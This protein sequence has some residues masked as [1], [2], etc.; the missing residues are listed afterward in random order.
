MTDAVLPFPLEGRD[1]NV[2]VGDQHPLRTVGA[3]NVRPSD[4]VTGRLSGSMRAGTAKWNGTALGGTQVQA[5]VGAMVDTGHLDHAEKQTALKAWSAAT[6]TGGDAA[7]VVFDQTGQAFIVDGGSTITIL[8]HTGTKG[9]NAST[10]T[11][12]V[13]VDNPRQRENT[14]FCCIAI[15]GY[16]RVYVGSSRGGVKSSARLVCLQLNVDLEDYEKLWELDLG[17]YI[18]R[19]RVHKAYLYA[20]INDTES[21]TA[22][23][24]KLQLLGAAMPSIEWRRAVMAPATGLDVLA[25]GDVVVSAGVNRTGRLVDPRYISGPR[26]SDQWAAWKPWSN[27][28]SYDDEQF[29]TIDPAQLE[30]KDGDP[31][32]TVLCADGSPRRLD[33]L[34]EAFVE[35][36][37]VGSLKS[38]GA[39]A[40]GTPIYT[41]RYPAVY[42][43]LVMFTSPGPSAG[44]TLSFESDTG[45]VETWT[46]VTATATQPY[47][48]VIGASLTATATNII[49]AINDSTAAT[50]AG[51]SRLVKARKKTTISTVEVVTFEALESTFEVFCTVGGSGVNARLTWSN[52]QG[53][54]IQRPV[55]YPTGAEVVGY[56]RSGK[57][58]PLRPPVYRKLGRAGFPALSFEEPFM[59][60]MSG[61][62]PNRGSAAEIARKTHLS[63]LPKWHA[64]Q[65]ST[66]ARVMAFWVIRPDSATAP[67]PVHT[68][69]LDKTSWLR[70][71]A[72]GAGRGEQAVPA[73]PYITAYPTYRPGA[74]ALS[75]NVGSTFHTFTGYYENPQAPQL[76]SSSGVV[77]VALVTDPEGNTEVFY[78]GWPGV[79]QR[80]PV[81]TGRAA[82]V[83]VS[84]AS[85]SLGDIFFRTTGNAYLNVVAGDLLYHT[86][87]ASGVATGFYYVL[88]ATPGVP[89][90]VQYDDGGGSPVNVIT[91]SIDEGVCFDVY[92]DATG[93]LQL[94]GVG[95]SI[96]GASPTH[97][98]VTAGTGLTNLP[99]LAEIGSIDD[100]D[101]VTLNDKLGINVVDGTIV[102]QAL[103]CVAPSRPLPGEA[104]G[105][106]VLGFDATWG[107]FRGDVLFYH[108]VSRITD[109]TPQDRQLWEGY[110]AWR[111]GISDA[112]PASHPHATKPPSS[113]G[114]TAG[115]SDAQK[116]TCDA[117]ALMK[118]RGNSGRVAWI[119]VTDDGGYGSGVSIGGLGVDC[120][121]D[122]AGGIYSI[123]MRTG[124]DDAQIR[125]VI[126]KGSTYSLA[127]GDGAW[128]DDLD[129]NDNITEGLNQYQS[130]RISVDKQGRLYVPTWAP[131]YQGI[132]PAWRRYERAGTL[133]YEHINTDKL[134]PYR[135]AISPLSNEVDIA[136]AGYP[137]RLVL[138]CQ[139]KR[140][141]TLTFSAQPAA[142]ATI[143]LTNPASG[144][145]VFTF[146]VGAPANEAE[147]Q[148]GADL[149]ASIQNLKTQLEAFNAS[150]SLGHC[151]VLVEATTATTITLLS[152][153]D[154]EEGELVVARSSSPAAN[155]TVGAHTISGDA[156]YAYD[157]VTSTLID[158]PREHFAVA[159]IGGGVRMATPTSIITPTGGLSL[160]SAA[161]Y[162]SCVPMFGHVFMVDGTS[163]LDLDLAKRTL[164]ELKPKGR[165]F[166]P[167]KC[168]ILESYL[169]A[170]F[171]AGDPNS[172][173]N[174]FMSKRGD[175]YD[176][177][178]YPFGGPFANQA[179]E[180]TISL[181]G[182]APVAINGAVNIVDDLLLILGDDQIWRL[183]G[184]PMSNGRFDMVSGRVGCAF[185]RAWE[186]DPAGRQVFFWNP[187]DGLYVTNGLQAEP[188]LPGRLTR[189]MRDIDLTKFRVRMAW[190]FLLDG[191][192]IF[193]CPLP[194]TTES[195]I[196]FWWDRKTNGLWEDSRS[197]S[198]ADVT[199]VTVINGD[200]P[201]DR[202][203]LMGTRAGFLAKWDPAGDDLGSPVNSWVLIGPIKAGN[204]RYETMFARLQV[205]LEQYAG[206]ATVNVYTSETASGPRRLR[207]SYTLTPGL[208]VPLSARTAGGY[209][210]IELQSQDR[211]VLER[212]SAVLSQ[213]SS[214]R[215]RVQ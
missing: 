164:S 95:L 157:V 104:F 167:Q 86:A 4:P 163:T 201:Q 119:A 62:N 42:C 49:N 206:S 11:P 193:V 196:S 207:H 178:Y 144:S 27:Y 82:L 133:T 26:L 105:R 198:T 109:W 151:H 103:V 185:G 153:V 76:V 181:A 143:T 99:I 102:A 111:F 169:G 2:S 100:D 155:C 187:D 137:T 8:Q 173:Q 50:E 79:A 147:V 97:V 94:N 184:D 46:F 63:L 36:G 140:T 121:H 92:R 72:N 10:I 58:A 78:N 191:L 75:Y 182:L 215:L 19:I 89:T 141:I 212:M 168:Q 98:L 6:Q 126:D 3:Q 39:E 150:A 59:S 14:E 132:P 172:R 56:C 23:A 130:L 85:N 55:A 165:G 101:R 192:D 73:D 93:E 51:A 65:A 136:G 70:L 161:S 148:I 87:G 204:P 205:V 142:N 183:T 176:Y 128:A 123:G 202:M 154:A 71:W 77:L 64:G 108:A 190:N 115:F 188:V 203:T 67:S 106:S 152:R 7:D 13:T 177:D 129:A 1:D 213:G 175:V 134:S 117:G 24:V 22:E 116:A 84:E 38:A 146:K 171:F 17:G 12:E 131:T 31:V 21:N 114:T 170:L 35:L 127:G 156:V 54:L 88:N 60:L 180:G 166:V 68:E 139:R 40:D 125:R 189:S 25:N 110:L 16:D 53:A 96:N 145:Q 160:N 107:S 30:A 138:A 48:I 28:G 194:G 66:A 214:R 91:N 210:W 186:V 112:L 200:N 5:L 80:G 208:N 74:L 122:G 81:L 18:T 162:V 69:R 209:I 149:A 61:R 45:D 20:L 199:D 120:A 83:G 174:W 135:V 32:T 9:T 179:T 124:S 113:D 195:P 34:P 158:T 57:D 47:D 15:D 90:T 29:V 41:N 118:F 43:G 197:V 33:F 52:H 37:L 159:V 44:D 211:W